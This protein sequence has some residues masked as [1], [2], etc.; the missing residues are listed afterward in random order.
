MADGTT[1]RGLDL[2]K[3]RRIFPSSPGLFMASR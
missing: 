3:V 1:E 2:A